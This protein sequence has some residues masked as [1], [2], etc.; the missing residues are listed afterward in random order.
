M[1]AFRKTALATGLLSAALTAG[2]VIAAPPVQRF[3]FPDEYY[4]YYRTW[5]QAR[6]DDVE[7]NGFELVIADPRGIT[8]AQVADLQDGV[9]D[10]AGTAD[11][12]KVLG[13]IS[14]G[15]DNRPSALQDPCNPSLGFK[16]I[17]GGQGPRVDP[18]GG[19]PTTNIASTVVN[20]TPSLGDPSPAG[21]GYERFYV[22][23]VGYESGANDGLPDGNAEFGGAYVNMGDPQWF[24]T[25]NN[26][27]RASTGAPSC[28]RTGV[29]GLKEIM[30]TTY[31]LGFGMDGIFMDAMEPPSQPNSF[32][33]TYAR[34]EWTAPGGQDLIR[35]IR[36]A[37]PGKI[38]LQN[39][40]LYYFHPQYEAYDFT[41]RPYID[42]LLYESYYADSN[43]FDTQ[44]PFYQTQN[45]Y[46]F[47]PKIAMEADREDGFTVVSL[48]YTEP[49]S[50]Y[51]TITIDGLISDWPEESAVQK[52]TF[53]AASDALQNVWITNDDTYVYLRV[54]TKAGGLD[55]A[56]WRFHAYFD[57]DEDPNDLEQVSDSKGWIV[58]TPDGTQPRMRSEFMMEGPW[59]HSQDASSFSRSQIGTALY[60]SDTAQENWEFRIPRNLTHPSTHADFPNQNVFG[61]D[62][63]H[64]LVLLTYTNTDS[65]VDA[66]PAGDGKFDANFGY[67]LEKPV[68]SVYDDAFDAAQKEA[69]FLT[70]L[71]DKFLSFPINSKTQDWNAANPDTSAPVWNTTANGFVPA[72]TSPPNSVRVGVQQLDAGDGQ[73]TVRWD[74]ANDQTRPVRYSIYYAPA[75][76][77]P[78]T[79]V[80]TPGWTS[81]GPVSGS[82]PT[83]Y[84]FGSGGWSANNSDVYANEHTVTGLQNGVE[85]RFI[86][87]AMDSAPTPHEDTNTVYLQAT[88][89]G[90]TASVYTSITVDGSVNEWP[91]EAKIWDDAVG[92][93]GTGPSDVKAVWAANDSEFV[94]L[95][96]DTHNAHDFP[97]QF[98]NIYL[99][100]DLSG[101][102][103]S[104]NPF[105]ANLIFS[106]LL[107]QGAAL[108]SQ[109][110]GNFND[111]FIQ[112][113]SAYVPIGSPGA[114]SW[115]ISI[116]RSLQHPSGAGGGDVFT[117]NGFKILI[118]SGSSLTDEIAGAASYNFAT[119]SVFKT[120]T[121]DGTIGS[122]EWPAS[123]LIYN[124]PS[125]DNAGAA[126]DI[127]AVHLANDTANLYLRVETWNTHDMPA[128]F[129]NFYFDTQA[130]IAPGFD[131]HGLGKISS[132]LLI[133]GV[134]AFSEG[135]GGFNDGFIQS[136]VYGPA[137]GTSA[138]VWEFAIPLGMTH[139]AGSGARAGQTVFPSPGTEIEILLTSDNGG[140]AEFAPDSGAL[141]YRIADLNI[142][143]QSTLATITVDG[144]TSDW[145]A[146]AKVQD[147]A[148]GDNGGAAS[149]IEAVWMANDSDYVY[150][151][152]DTYNSHDYIAAFNNSYFDSDL[153]AST[154]FTPHS[155]LFGS[156]MLLQNSGVF[157]QKGGGF[158]E[159]AC[160]S[161]SGKTVSVAPASGNATTWEW[162][163][164]RDLQHPGG[165]GSVFS[166]PDQSFFFFTT[167]DNAGFAEGAPDDP[168]TQ[169]IWY[170]PAN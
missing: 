32:T 16:T 51:Q 120:I 91:A 14:V 3:S 34:S 170:V 25:I 142:T 7:T 151:R 42:I 10:T 139:S 70:Y 20:G 121:A 85:Y 87:R 112:N 164:P 100:T 90:G 11:D 128:A 69:G 140:P 82:V 31:G 33:P 2:G 169:F 19:N 149:D 154:G 111:G 55:L 113:A 147:D 99:D 61:T 71:T 153:K 94:Y 68:G 114:T 93:N 59:L 124:D 136:L 57:M 47:G 23:D 135:N 163:I 141:R 15:E 88:P 152:I 86:V 104:F 107:L 167:S 79:N 30:T 62:G 41:T 26:M 106:E 101:S 158:N 162:R 72:G 9:D 22:D 103:T 138:T 53:P 97:N 8:P 24:D 148:S 145:P 132:K 155:L 21:T 77:D 168:S 40:A 96:I 64:F 65:T 13:Y 63:D 143:P 134:S 165:G 137:T 92:D 131:P 73:I 78:G 95:R 144:L 38:L 5:D 18:R 50:V 4:I 49:H 123:S 116:P 67:R 1:S 54:Q 27:E 46:D 105:G 35:R 84:R 160:T 119:A 28:G 75:S 58:N 29:S 102:D 43:D 118:A 89:T 110:N 44:S 81:T 129:N 159:G 36:E 161:S 48:D 37:F 150:V 12:I 17:P 126:T 156:E 60:A 146:G 115:E 166:Q 133:N 157:S 74:T 6:I 130:G 108:Y 83:T 56:N 80:T 109:K 98:N 117:S 76:P 39:R 45:R 66:V 127:K 125:G 52:N 122:G